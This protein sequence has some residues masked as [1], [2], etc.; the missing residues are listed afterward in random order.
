MES[1]PQPRVSFGV[2]VY[3]EEGSIRRCLDSILAQDF[4]DFEVVVCDNASTDRTPEILASYAARDARVRVVRNE[5]NLGLIRNWNRAF[6]LSRGTYFRW[7]GGDDWLEATYTSRCVAALDADPAAILATSGFMMHYPDGT[8]RSDTFQGERLESNKPSRRLARMFWFLHHGKAT[9][10]EPLQSL[11]RR[12]V[13][14]RTGLLRLI[15]YNDYMLVTELSVAGRFMHVP[16]VLFHRGFRPLENEQENVAKV[17]PGSGGESESH[18]LT[19]VRVLSS[20]VRDAPMS[21]QERLLCRATAARF[22]TREL[23]WL[24]Q[25]ELVRFR[26]ERLGLTRARLRQLLGG[27]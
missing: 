16:D 5:E 6:Q 19:M 2:P 13:L 9:I 17:M 25:S 10:Y 7:L 4:S 1:S 15:R 22:C 11:I 23:L 3:N 8:T 14:E 18:F 26:R 12:G 27:R 21:P 20:I 24:W